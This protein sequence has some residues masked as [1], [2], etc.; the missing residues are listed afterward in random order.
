[1]TES[2][3][4]KVLVRIKP[5]QSD[6]IIKVDDENN[7][8]VP[9]AMPDEIL[10]FP[11]D[12][13]FPMSATQADV[14][15]A[16]QSLVD[17]V[18]LGKNATVFAYGQTGAGKTHSIIGTRQDPGVLPRTV[19][20]LLARLKAVGGC[21][22]AGWMECYQDKLF[23]LRNRKASLDLYGDKNSTRV[24]GLSFVE[25]EDL[26]HF[27]KEHDAAWKSRAT[28]ATKLNLSSSRSHF[29][30]QL[31]AN[32]STGGKTYCSKLN[33]CDLAG[34]ENNKKTGNSGERMSESKAIN[35]SLF[36]LGRVV[37]ALNQSSPNVSYRNSI[38][39]RLLQDALGG[40]ACATVLACLSGDDYMETLSTLKFGAKCRS[41]QN[42]VVI[43]ETTPVQP[44]KDD[45]KRPV[46][47]GEVQNPKRRRSPLQPSS[48]LEANR[49]DDLVESLLKCKQELQERLVV[50]E[51]KVAA[52]EAVPPVPTISPEAQLKF[53]QEETEKSLIQVINTES[54]PGLMRLKTIGPS[55]A[56][57][58]LALREKLGEISSLN[59]LYVILSPAQTELLIKANMGMF[60]SSPT[61]S[62]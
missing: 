6:S 3:K 41:I 60:L 2:L 53:I 40:S 52:S 39:T 27:E 9:G 51:A 22:R 1:M 28:A 31:H 58:I 33:V 44:P 10:V 18:L 11:F 62:K 14:Y 54:L 15:A 49:S 24:Q 35:R 43:N 38:L 19:R 4:V 29:V 48:S 20:D 25:I 7:V 55:R 16:I 21:L 47:A 56:S 5:L 45:G 57:K 17:Q 34:S 30:L 61:L 59:D 42:T 12:R 23:D 50:M 26:D 46:G 36:E 8:R 37:E 13:V 32:F